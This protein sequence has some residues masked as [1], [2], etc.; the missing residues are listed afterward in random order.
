MKLNLE[1]KRASLEDFDYTSVYV[2]SSNLKGLIYSH[3]T[4]PIIKIS[5]KNKSIYR[6]LRSKA[7]EGL[8]KNSIVIDYLSKLE[9]DANYGDLLSIEKASFI[10]HIFHY[11]RKNPNEDIRLAWYFFVIN[12]LIGL[13]SI[14]LTLCF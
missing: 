2:H 9:L 7:I 1:L 6:K 3:H 5:F 12:I 14:I 4:R 11:F 8:D 13:I 10:N